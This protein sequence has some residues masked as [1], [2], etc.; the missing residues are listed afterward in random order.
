MTERIVDLLWQ[1]AYLSLYF[2]GSSVVY[3]VMTIRGAEN[4]PSGLA[5]I[6]APLLALCAALT[7]LSN[8]VTANKE[9]KIPL[10]EV[11]PGVFA[12][13]SAYFWVASSDYINRHPSDWKLISEFA[14]FF[15]VA[16]FVALFSLV[17]FLALKFLWNLIKS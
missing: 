12:V 7:V 9:A 5:E 14:V 15:A 8:T 1:W 2:L 4:E 10:Q 11:A 3:A 13:I 16:G 17:A 6:G